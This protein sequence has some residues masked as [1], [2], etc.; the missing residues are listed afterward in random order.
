M[1]RL[2]TSILLT[3]LMS[4]IGTMAFAHDFAVDNKDGVTIY[5]VKTSDTEVAVTFQGSSCPSYVDYY[6]PVNIPTSVTYED[7]TYSVTGITDNAFYCWFSM[8]SI[9]IPPTVTSIGKK[10]FYGCEDLA[11]VTIPSSVKSLG[12]MAFGSCQ[13]MKKATIINGSMSMGEGVFTDC[14]ELASVTLPSSMTSIP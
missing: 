9:Y 6:G 2:Y 10:A 4:M 12:D 5:Y 3:M 14:Q 11:E 1:K 7:K 8:T 13:H